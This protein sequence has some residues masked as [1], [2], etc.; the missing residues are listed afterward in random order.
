MIVQPLAIIHH[1]D[2]SIPLPAGHRFPMGKFTAL[3]AHLR[4]IGLA[5]DDHLFEA[6]EA[7]RHWLTLAHSAS[8]VD[9]M[10]AGTIDPKIMRA[11]GLPWS[12]LLVRRS[13]LAAGG[14]VLCAK[15]ALERG[16]ACHTAGGS[17]HAASDAG[18]G[19]CVFNDVA[20]AI[21]VLMAEGAIQRALVIDLDVHQGDGTARIF[22]SDPSVY[23][24][25]MHGARNFPVRKAASDLDIE[26]ED[27][28][29]DDDYLRIL[30]HH[31]PAILSAARADIVFYIAGVD[32]HRDDLLGRLGLSDDGLYARDCAVIGAVCA[33][34][35][36][37]VG[38]LGGGYAKDVPALARRHAGLHRA[39]A[40]HLVQ[41]A[42]MHAAD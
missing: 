25:S 12:P 20:V 21:R 26:L 39:A 30:H 35:I 24:F 37:L 41:S 40:A 34:G 38:V 5:N 23:T 8:Y 7:P 4:Q 29:G 16:I 11:I 2:F 27:G 19:F 18:S 6:A 31:L 22:A 36:P 13:R 1:P 42:H 32:P 3:M 10:M 14:T 33:R 28:T 15:L 17:H 9:D